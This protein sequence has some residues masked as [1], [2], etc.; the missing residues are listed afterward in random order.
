[1]PRL[2][3]RSTVLVLVSVTTFFFL[4]TYQAQANVDLLYFRAES[5][6][7]SV[8]LEWETAS[9]LDN[10]GFNILRSDADDISSAVVINP[11]LIPSLVG[12]QPIGA[13]YEWPDDDV[14]ANI[15][16]SYWLQ[17]IDF[18][19]GVEEHGPIEA[20]LTSGNT[21]PTIPPVN[22]VQPTETLVNTPEPSPSRTIV[23]TEQVVPT[24]SATP[25]I[26]ELPTRTPTIPQSTPTVI[27]LQPTQSEGDN[28]QPTEVEETATSPSP[29]RQPTIISPVL[30]SSE[31]NDPENEDQLTTEVF[32]DTIGE[33]AP[34][35]NL[36]DPPPNI[37]G[38]Q[39]TS[40]II[41]QSIGSDNPL[42]SEAA[43]SAIESDGASAST[44]T[45]ATII[46]IAALLLALGGG[47]V[48]WLLLKPQIADHENE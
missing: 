6:T 11:F 46:L 13:Y 23:P 9:E 38:E 41:P 15:T 37:I 32:A 42:S 28:Q 3:G 25:R 26:A 1:M 12:G 29:S 48:V 10:L 20:S 33:Q 24:S 5:G 40:G 16:Y 47:I 4:A 14:E 39:P 2:R 19:G 34:T 31:T 43:N 21:I 8:T 44:S 22:T 45:L 35:G 17:D 30:S 36:Q 18:N 7:D 27:S